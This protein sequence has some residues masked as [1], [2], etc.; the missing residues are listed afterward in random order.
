MKKIIIIFLITITSCNY[1]WSYKNPQNWGDLK[2]EYKFCKIGYNQSPIDIKR[3]FNNKDL[4]FSYSKDGFEKEREKYVMKFNFD[5][6]DYVLR[7][8][9]KYFVNH[10]EFHHPSEH[11]IDSKPYSLEMQ[12][13]HKSDDE[14]HL[15]IAIFL[16]IG[17]ENPSFNQIIAALK[18]NEKQQKIDLSK[19][20]KA[21]DNVFFYDGS[22]TTPPCKEG[23]KWYVMKTPIKISKTQMNQIIKGAIF[24]KANARPTQAFHDEKY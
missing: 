3:E 5:H 23:L 6:K 13:Y 16:E 9:R 2:E 7:A 12:I 11:L 1:D 21:D 24:S 19:I 20:I 17:E 22:A 10:F 8:K 18:N 4:T 15:A 14:Q